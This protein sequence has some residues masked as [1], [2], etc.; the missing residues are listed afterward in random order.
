[1]EGNCENLKGYVTLDATKVQRRMQY[2]RLSK[3]E[4]VAATGLDD[5]TVGKAISGERCQAVTACLIARVLGL[6]RHEDLMPGEDGE[7]LTTDEQATRRTFGEWI[8]L[9]V[10]SAWEWTSNR[11]QYEVC[12]MQHRH[13]PESFGR[14]KCYNLRYMS[15]D[16]RSEA[17]NRLVRHPAVCDRMGTHAAFPRNKRA[18]YE[19]KDYFWIIDAWE[20]GP[21]LSE[22]LN[23]G[24]LEPGRLRQLMCELAEGLRVLH[25]NEI[26]RRE[27]TPE[28]IILRASDHSV[29]LTDLEL[30]KL[31][32][33]SP[34]VS[35]DWKVNPYVA[36]EVFSGKVDKRADLFSWGQILYHASAGKAP[37]KLPGTSLF[38]SLD[39]PRSV[40]EMA[41]SCVSISP[42]MRPRSF[43]KVVKAIRNWR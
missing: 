2:C 24:P 4:L 35:R 16:E 10:L 38:D 27:L 41:K 34:T 12:K 15:D 37:P 30:A 5:R 33:G 9:D 40:K 28:F 6:P 1:M 13:V 11:L 3:S 32:D 26:I 42:S 23:R 29:L 31:L 17:E 14:G 22:I 19:G 8:V 21:S 39:L 18:D 20:E 7:G 36:P 25:E 43:R